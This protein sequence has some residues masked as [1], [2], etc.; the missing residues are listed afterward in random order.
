MGWVGV[1]GWALTFALL[2]P[3]P[4]KIAAHPVRMAPRAPVGDGI[5]SK[6]LEPKR[7]P[8]SCDHRIPTTEEHRSRAIRFD[9]SIPRPAHCTHHDL[10]FQVICACR[11][12]MV[13]STRSTHLLSALC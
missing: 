3:W 4:R 5:V 9:M 7:D 1:V 2:P 8:D 10:S 11:A 12:G 6:G 13:G